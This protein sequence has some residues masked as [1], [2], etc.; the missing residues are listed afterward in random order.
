M[1]YDWRNR[2]ICC[3]YSSLIH[4][5]IGFTRKDRRGLIEHVTP[6]NLASPYLETSMFKLSPIITFSPLCWLSIIKEGTLLLGHMKSKVNNPFM[7]SQGGPISK[8]QSQMCSIR[9]V[10]K[11]QQH[12]HRI[13]DPR[14]HKKK[15]LEK[16]VLTL[17]EGINPRKP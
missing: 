5:K 14:E 11:V 6:L 4:H 7:L 2:Y 15:N 3:I 13:I 9:W 8:V 17:K 16:E 10:W 1:K 12:L